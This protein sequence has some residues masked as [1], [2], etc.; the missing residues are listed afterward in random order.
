MIFS[1]TTLASDR[2][3]ICESCKHFRKT[4]RTCGTPV[5]GNK[6]GKKRL[7]GCFMDIKTTLKFASC[8]MNKWD[9]LQI[10]HKEYL[11]VKELLDSTKTSITSIQQQQLRFYGEKYLGIK[12]Q[13][14]S[15]APCVKNNL[16]RLQQIIN[17][18]EK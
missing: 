4:T 8:P 7:C 9:G 11:E 14:S 3:A 15:C 5:K 16:N 12:I 17:E 10:T 13:S 1:S 18:Y 6:I 2:I